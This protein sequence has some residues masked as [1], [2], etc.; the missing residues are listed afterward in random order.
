MQP[1]N[2]YKGTEVFLDRD[3][4]CKTSRKTDNIYFIG[5]DCQDIDCTEC[6]FSGLNITNGDFYHW[7]SK[8]L[9]KNKLERILNE[10]Y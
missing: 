10:N 2:P 8:R 6:L 4:Y 3:G 1:I 5:A 7:N 9:R